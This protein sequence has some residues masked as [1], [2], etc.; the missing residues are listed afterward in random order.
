MGR[1]HVHAFV[2]PVC[3]MA[4]MRAPC[5]II[6]VRA[7]QCGPNILEESL[8]NLP[9]PALIRGGFGLAGILLARGFLGVFFLLE[10]GG[11]GNEL[12]LVVGEGLIP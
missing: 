6:L 3:F 2:H 1:R 10:V 12:G 8:A 5:I 11:K 9:G 7:A 4:M